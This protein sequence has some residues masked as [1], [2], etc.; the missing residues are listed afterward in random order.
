[1]GGNKSRELERKI[2]K[3]K[4]KKKGTL[5][6]VLHWLKTWGYIIKIL[7]KEILF[8]PKLTATEGKSSNILKG[9]S[10]NI[11]EEGTKQN[12]NWFYDHYSC[13][14]RLKQSGTFLRD[15]LYKKNFTGVERAMTFPS[16]PQ[17]KC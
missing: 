13:L 14:L 11:S 1:M 17:F 9:Y 8:D 7:R 5:Q 12:P 3:K 16:I 4:K 10:G 6:N 15:T 2:R